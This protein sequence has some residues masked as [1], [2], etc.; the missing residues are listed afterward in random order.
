MRYT[1]IQAPSWCSVATSRY[2]GPG[3]V[4]G[5]AG[6]M[7]SRTPGSRAPTVEARSV[8]AAVDQQDSR[9]R[10][11]GEAG[12]Y[13]PVRVLLV[14]H[15][16]ADGMDLRALARRM[17]EA[18]F[19]LV[20]ASSVH[21]AVHR[22]QVEPPAL[23]LLDLGPGPSG[24]AALR[25]LRRRSV[26]PII[27]LSG[28]AEVPHRV[29][30]LED[31]ADDYLPKPFDANELAARI[32]AVLRRGRSSAPRDSL[33]VGPLEMDLERRICR[34]EG[35]VVP[36]ARSEWRVLAY[37]AHNVGRVVIAT[38]ILRQCW[39]PGYVD[40]LQILRICIS[41]LRR[42]IGGTGRTGVIRTYHNV[43]YALE[44]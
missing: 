35:T 2:G 33:S 34:V 21:E 12:G 29:Q 41:R 11:S 31:G 8:V 39:G 15:G 36:L 40:D 20:T 44:A 4:L 10:G 19:H 17:A 37:L 24:L 25:Q 38:E 6:G 22:L 18:G 28:T 30:T 3:G 14:R 23:M 5:K 32:R 13:V 42:K 7:V 9:A 26:P 1:E 43:G 27:V 16:P